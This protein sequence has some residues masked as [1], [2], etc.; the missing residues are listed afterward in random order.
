MFLLSTLGQVSNYTWPLG[1]RKAV[2][3]E[4]QTQLQAPQNNHQPQQGKNGA[5]RKRSRGWH[6]RR[7]DWEPDYHREQIAMLT[8]TIKRVKLKLRAALPPL[9][10]QVPANATD[11]DNINRVNYF[12]H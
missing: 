9:R 8:K 7:V 10:V 4:I 3:Q 6:S 2:D 12:K 1:Q 11:H 5:L